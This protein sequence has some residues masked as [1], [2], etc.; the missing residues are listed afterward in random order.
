MKPCVAFLLDGNI[1]GAS[2]HDAAFVIAIECR[3][4]GLTKMEAEAVLTRWAYKIG[5]SS[6]SATRAIRSGYGKKPDGTW[7][8]YPPG[9]TKKPGS[10]YE[11]VLGATCIDV[12]CPANCAPFA[13][14]HRGLRATW[15]ISH[16]EHLGWPKALRKIRHAPPPTITAPS[17]SW[18]SSVAS[19]PARRCSRPT[20]NSQPSPERDRRHAGDNLDVLLRTLGLLRKFERGS[21]SG[22]HA[23]DRVASRV[24]RADPIPPVPADIQAAIQNRW[25][26][27]T[28]DRGRHASRDR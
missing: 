9:V 14:V 27:V 23:S 22:P 26:A 15:A 6:R 19:R 24:V 10:K 17:V 7:R 2:R 1:G 28:P 13:N 20:R 18:S 11:S 4:I 25:R 3:R 21:G 16:F 8:Y 12:G 5:Y